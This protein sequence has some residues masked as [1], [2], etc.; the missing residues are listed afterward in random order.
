MTFSL[1]ARDEITGFYGI[2]VASR[3]FAVG[4]TIPHFGQNCAVASQALV[5]PMWGVAGREHLSAGMSASEALDATKIL[6]NG[7]SQRQV[8]MI[9]QRGRTAAHTGAD[10]IGWAGH[11][12]ADGVSVAGNMLENDQVIAAMMQ[13]YNDHKTVEFASRILGAMQAGESAGGDSRGQQSASLTIHRGELFPWLDLRSDDHDAPLD[14][15]ERLL[16]V[17]QE[18]Y[19]HFTELMGHSDNFSGRADRTKIDAAIEQ[20]EK[21]RRQKGIMSA[22]RAT[23]KS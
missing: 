10:C 21:E 20:G 11:L 1:I 16:A 17:A 2:A 6:D 15:I 9:D 12:T 13:Y 23:T 4:A 22:S 3:F 14:E 19:I 5:N 18:R 7:Q 8:H